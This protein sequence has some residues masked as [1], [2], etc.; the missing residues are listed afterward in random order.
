MDCKEAKTWLHSYLDGELDLART[1][2]IDS[3]LETCPACARARD[4]QRVL[5]GSIHASSLQ[6]RCPDRLR[7]NIESMVCR[8]LG[9]PNP[10]SNIPRWWLAIAA[11]LLL[12]AAVSWLAQRQ[13]S[14]QSLNDRIAEQVVASHVRSLLADH[15]M[16]VVSSDRHTVKPWF[17]GKLDFAPVVVDLSPEGFPLIG[18]RLDYLDHRPVAVVVYQ[19]RQHVINLFVWP[20]ERPN[21]DDLQMKTY[22]GYHVVRWNQAGATYWAISDLN[23]SELSQFSHLVCD[24]AHDAGTS[25][26]PAK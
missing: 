11:S 3:H 26:Y 14:G 6:W 10:R 8:E 18:G 24:A 20:S 17:A 1:M 12:L 13:M 25:R 22:Q 21:D 5:R 19:R 4:N 15:L 9:R 16:D 23:A 2:E 7:T